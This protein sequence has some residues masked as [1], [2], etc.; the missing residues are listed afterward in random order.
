MAALLF[1]LDGTI[2]DSAPGIVTCARTALAEFGACPP[3]EADLRWLIGPPLRASMERLLGGPEHVEAC[4][5]AYRR[6]YA[7]TGLLT[8]E[9]FG[10]VA[11]ELRRLREAGHELIV[12]TSKMTRF[13]EPIIDRF[14]L[15]DLFAGIYGAEPGHDEAKSALA[16]RI[17]AQHRL[18]P[19]RACLIG[20]RREDIRAGHENGLATVGVLW[21]YGGRDELVEAGAHRL[22]ETPAS[23]SADLHAL[24]N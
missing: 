9:P 20:D 17:V 10:G 12:C 2:A 18:D 14:G 7:E 24:L 11:D 23:L 16:A 6:H 1:D 4:V 15:T 19:N 5:A 3:P 21:G 8:V 22:C 13:A